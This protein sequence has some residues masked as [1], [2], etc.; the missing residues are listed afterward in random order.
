MASQAP[1]MYRNKLDDI[2]YPAPM[3]R[4]HARPDASQ[5]EARPQPPHN[6]GTG[7]ANHTMAQAGSLSDSETNGV[8]QM[9]LGCVERMTAYWSTRMRGMESMGPPPADYARL[10]LWVHDF[11][12]EALRA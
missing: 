2:F 4:V 7:A 1:E 11:P 9:C 3:D 6:H 8:P 5:P 10:A 12:F